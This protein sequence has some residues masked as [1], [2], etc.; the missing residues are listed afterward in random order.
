MDPLLE[1]D[2]LDPRLPEAVEERELIIPS[3]LHGKL[4]LPQPSHSHQS[5]PT[6]LSPKR[7]GR[8]LSP[9]NGERDEKE[10]QQEFRSFNFP[11]PTKI[12]A[13]ETEGWRPGSTRGM[14]SQNGEEKT[15]GEEEGEEVMVGEWKVGEVLGNGTSGMVYW[16][17]ST[18]DGTFS[19][20]KKV[21]KLPNSHKES[22]LVHREIALMKLV[23]PH[24][25]LVELF[26][27]YESESNLYLVTEYCPH[28]ELF[29]YVSENA[30]TRVER[31]RFYS[32]LISALLHLSKFSI[33]HRDIKFENLLLYKG[34]QGLLS[35][36]V[37]DMGMSTVQLEGQSLTTSCGS[38]HYAAPEVIRGTPY[39][40][41]LADVWSAGVCLFAMIARRLPF[42]D[43]D[44]PKLLR[45]IKEGE[46]EMDDKIEGSERELV[47]GSLRKDPKERLTLQQISMHSYTFATI[48]VLGERFQENL[49]SI[50]DKQ[51]DK[52][53]EPRRPRREEEFVDFENLE[54]TVMASLGIVLKVSDLEQVK[55]M[56]RQDQ[57]HSRFFYSKLLEFR[58]SR[59]PPITLTL[60]QIYF[61]EEHWDDNLLRFDDNDDDSMD[62]TPSLF[63]GPP[64]SS[65]PPV[66]P[67]F[68]PFDPNS[69]NHKFSF[70]E[71]SPPNW[72][73]E[74]DYALLHSLGRSEPTLAGSYD[75]NKSLRS[76]PPQTQKFPSFLACLHEFGPIASAPPQIE[77]FPS[78][79]IPLS[80]RVKDD[81]SKRNSFVSIDT[82]LPFLAFE[83]SSRSRG[84][85]NRTETLDTS[86]D[87]TT[88]RN[89]PRKKPSMHQRLRSLLSTPL[90]PRANVTSFRPPSPTGSTLTTASRLTRSN[91]Y[92]SL[93]RAL[94]GKLSPSPI[95]PVPSPS[96]TSI[97]ELSF[98]ERIVLETLVPSFSPI[99]SLAPN[100]R[101]KKKGGSISLEEFIEEEVGMSTVKRL[102]T[103]KKKKSLGILNFF[104]DDSSTS[105]A[106]VTVVNSSNV[107]S[108]TSP[109]SSTTTA[110][111]MAQSKRSAKVK[112]RPQALSIASSNLIAVN[113]S[114]RSSA[115]AKKLSLL[116][117]GPSRSTH[118]LPPSPLTLSSNS[119][120]SNSPNLPLPSSTTQQQQRSKPRSSTITYVSQPPVLP[121][122]TI[123][124]RRST[125]ASTLSTPSSSS[126]I[127]TLQS[128]TSTEP[129]AALKKEI[130]TLR[131]EKEKLLFENHLLQTRLESKEAEVEMLRK[132]EKEWL[133]IVDSALGRTGG[134]GGGGAVQEEEESLIR[135]EGSKTQFEDEGESE[136]GLGIGIVEAEWVTS[137]ERLSKGFAL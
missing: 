19:A 133:Q 101:Q 10:W 25:N 107:S 130:A 41:S 109:D 63:P 72:T 68:P 85:S 57:N 135:Q 137:L 27:V 91:A 29:Q 50:L 61:D 13:R 123:L 110:G 104:Y 6:P 117:I 96:T 5:K 47:E 88:S 48:F 14:Q 112:R 4:P 34:D 87:T 100:V 131:L 15:E 94:L 17:R 119:P 79:P 9:T 62:I 40:G 75:E 65:E 98:A 84:S 16:G 105:S 54:V 18:K 80:P 126:R 31:C 32:Q 37:A 78:Q 8:L 127:G 2:D 74:Y 67:S 20:I 21:R 51:D 116:A 111:S 12:A 60:Q 89:G 39:D 103:K 53:E 93:G 113:A 3:P 136:I 22:A 64:S 115:L 36:K 7:T 30:L 129:S 66:S 55:E 26:D 11:R 43:P 102:T 59:R 52:E 108:P 56:L 121:F 77:S 83:G 23:S 95:F 97:N 120:N 28:G 92:R 82:S 1:T 44:V 90:S 122:P 58:T 128:S 35:L 134:G 99:P 106:S 73:S 114:T 71:T 132:R 81:I 69:F 24:P 42:D 33:A 49:Q 45:M 46:Y 76:A 38:P 125:F 70:N 118:L 124:R 86:R